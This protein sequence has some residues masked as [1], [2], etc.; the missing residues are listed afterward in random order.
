MSKAWANLFG[1]ASRGF[2]QSF[3][4]AVAFARRQ[5]IAQERQTREDKLRAAD[6]RRRGEERTHQ[7][8]RE[9][10]RRGVLDKRWTTTQANRA[11]R[12]AATADYRS[13]TARKL[14]EHRET[15]AGLQRSAPARQAAAQANL[16]KK[17]Q[18]TEAIANQLFTLK[19]QYDAEMKD[20]KPPSDPGGSLLNFLAPGTAPEAPKPPN[21][22]GWLQGKA[23]PAVAGGYREGVVPKESKADASGRIARGRPGLSPE[24][25]ANKSLLDSKLKTAQVALR[26]GLQNNDINA[27]QAMSY[28]QDVAKRLTVPGSRV[29]RATLEAASEAYARANG[30][31]RE[32]QDPEKLRAAY[33][34]A[35]EALGFNLIDPNSIEE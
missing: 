29:P 7:E 35:Y 26:E 11:V 13:T 25:R 19:Q 34:N 10:E 2:S 12:D 22:A 6:L 16:A 3:G 18:N 28:M 1:G 20:W 31:A 24:Y 8:G 17:K 15:M 4:P 32:G 23:L 5:R 21:F 14:A 27:T 9:D 33:L 30:W